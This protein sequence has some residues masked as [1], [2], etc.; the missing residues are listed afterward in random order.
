MP[1]YHHVSVPFMCGCS[2]S[3][4]T[5]IHTHGHVLRHVGYA[6]L[7][8][9]LDVG[10]L[11][12]REAVSGLCSMARLCPLPFPPDLT[13]KL[14]QTLLGMPHLREAVT[15]PRHDRNPAVIRD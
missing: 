6:F 7:A 1:Q 15:V 8:H 4:H 10:A 14:Y 11:S 3:T 12:P 5:H 9:A 2:T 13:H